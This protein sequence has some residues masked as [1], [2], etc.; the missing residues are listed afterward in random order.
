[1]TPCRVVS[2]S[3]TF[4]NLFFGDINGYS[5]IHLSTLLD[6]DHVIPHKYLLLLCLSIDMETHPGSQSHLLQCNSPQCLNVLNC[7][8]TIPKDRNWVSQVVLRNGLLQCFNYVCTFQGIHC[9]H[10]LLVYK[11]SVFINYKSIYSTQNYR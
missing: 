8:P 1:M 11:A 4:H 10:L 2:I 7:V 6:R 5:A 3:R 9:I